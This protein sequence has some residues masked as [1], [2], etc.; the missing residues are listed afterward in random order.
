MPKLHEIQL[1]AGATRRLFWG[2]AIAAWVAIVAIIGL[3]FW[4]IRIE[5]SQRPV[6]VLA[7]INGYVG[8]E[9]FAHNFLLVWLAGGARDAEKLSTMT[10][11]PGQPELNP[12][13][14]TVL[15]INAVPPVTRTAAGKETEWGLTLAATLIAPGSSGTSAR[16]YFRVTFVEAG[17][18]YKALM[19]PRPVNNT[20]RAVQINSSYTHGLD[21]TGPLGAQ[22]SA[23]MTAFYTKDSAGS[24]GNFVSSQFSETAI[25]GSP[26]TTVQ[27][28]SILAA[29]DTRD[30][31]NATPGTTV[32]VLVAAKAAASTD[33]F[34]L[35]NAPLRMTLSNN[36]QWLVDGFDDPV[37]FGAVSYK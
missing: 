19:W 2:T 27:V 7:E 23:F 5:A 4:L 18:T 16:N 11:L 36:K 15:D 17:G 30:T 29:K 9:F 20:A 34:S 12:D 31:A 32:H 13:P 8:A 24:L 28:T 35:I 25:K 10:A 1:T 6:N 37:H 21:I 3:V 14:F 33:T 22:V 26:Y